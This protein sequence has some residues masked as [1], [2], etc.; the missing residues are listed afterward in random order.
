MVDFIS[1]QSGNI[2]EIS[3]P[4]LVTATQFITFS[5]LPHL[6]K[7]DLPRLVSG[8]PA[9]LLAWLPRLASFHVPRLVTSSSTKIISTPSLEELVLPSLATIKDGASQ[10]ISSW[11][12]DLVTYRCRH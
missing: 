12:M 9:I 8:K 4:S 3:L 5:D 7:I 2:T 11:R 1:F 6:I 10:A